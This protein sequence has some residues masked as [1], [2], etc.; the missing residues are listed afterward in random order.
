MGGGAFYLEHTGGTVR[1]EN[2][3]FLK[4]MANAENK[5]LN[6]FSNGGVIGYYCDF[7]SFIDMKNNTFIL[8]VADKSGV[9]D[10]LYGNLKDLGSRFYSY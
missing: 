9:I 1:F 8:N 3:F 10:G 4:N 6:G 7:N 5:A 2:N